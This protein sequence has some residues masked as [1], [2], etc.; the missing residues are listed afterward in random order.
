M[1]GQPRNMEGDVNQQRQAGRDDREAPF[2]CVAA[3]GS[4]GRRAPGHRRVVA[5]LQPRLG[6]RVAVVGPLGRPEAVVLIQAW[7]EK[8]SP[9]A[10][11]TPCPKT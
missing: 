7:S 2:P 8:L 10:K 4:V 11:S 3:L 1:A 9:G 5:R 6:R